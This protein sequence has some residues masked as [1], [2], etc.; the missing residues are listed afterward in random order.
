MP[1]VTI[2]A[3]EAVSRKPIEDGAYEG[4]I[5]EV[6]GPHKGPKSSYLKAT[7]GIDVDGVQRKVFRN[8]P[9]D[10][11]GAGITI[12]FINK[13]TGSEHDVDDLSK[14]ELDTDDLIGARIGVQIKSREY[15]E[16]SG[17]MQPEIT[18]V[19]SAR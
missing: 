2:D 1:R 7:I 19:L 8:L 15:P 5:L 9:I 17:E 16:G 18:R 6:D 10:K 3:S 14:L 4:E 11:A 13:A 12:D